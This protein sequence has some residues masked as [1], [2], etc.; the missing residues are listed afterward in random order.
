[1]GTLGGA[2]AMVHPQT[3]GVCQGPVHCRGSRRAMILTSARL[4]EAARWVE[5]GKYGPVGRRG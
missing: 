4:E 1:M 2:D 3:G 5:Y